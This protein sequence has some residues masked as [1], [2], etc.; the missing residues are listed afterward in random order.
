MSQSPFAQRCLIRTY[1]CLI[2]TIY[3]YPWFAIDHVLEAERLRLFHCTKMSIRA[4]IN[5]LS[6]THGNHR[7]EPHKP[8]VLT[9]KELAVAALIC[10]GFTEKEKAQICADL[11]NSGYHQLTRPQG[12]N[13]RFGGNHAF[14]EEWPFKVAAKL[15]GANDQ[16]MEVSIIP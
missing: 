14:A 12:M 5:L 6:K 8:T 4:L 13:I 3:K 9:L 7:A 15:P 10:P 1:E 16:L 2:T 11:R